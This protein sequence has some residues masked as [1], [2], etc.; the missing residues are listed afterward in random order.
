M[1]RKFLE[2]CEEFDPIQNESPK[3]KLIDFL[4]SQGI[5]VS[6]V[7]DTDMLYIDTGEDTI[8]VTIS[9]SEEEA[10]N[11]DADYG[12]YRVNDEVENLAGKADGGLKG[13]AKKVL[14]NPAQRAKSAVKKRQGVVKSAI[15]TYDKKTQKLQNDIRN[16]QI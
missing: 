7:G 10:E 4:K 5:K 9:A 16:V 2:L 6:L 13:A 11:V 14:G 1:S 12:N 15:D 3:W 8:P